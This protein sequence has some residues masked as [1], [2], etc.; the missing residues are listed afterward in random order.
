MAFDTYKII[1]PWNVHSGDDS[2][3]NVIEMN[4]IVIEALVKGQIKNIHIKNAHT[5]STS[6]KQFYIL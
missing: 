4:N 5:M 1:A 2:V 6:C 3:L